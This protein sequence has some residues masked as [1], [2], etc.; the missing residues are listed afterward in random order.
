MDMETGGILIGA[1]LIGG[2]V[3]AIAGGATL[4]TFPAML[5]AG[6]PPLIANVSNAVAVAPGH[7]MAALADRRQLPARDHRLIATTLAVT[8]GGAAG[9]WLLLVTP[10]HLFTALVPALTGL[11]TRLFALGE[12]VRTAIPGR[13]GSGLLRACTAAGDR[14]LW[15]LFRRRPRRHLARRAERHEPGRDPD[16]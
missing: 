4:I 1:G 2:V 15:R 3:N 11:A 8:A 16:R 12:R 6:L 5:A 10:E 14:D 7:L 9:A 13:D